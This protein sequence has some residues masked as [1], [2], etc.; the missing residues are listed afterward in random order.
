MDGFV[1]LPPGGPPP[2]KLWRTLDGG[3]SWKQITLP[4]GNLAY[5]APTS[6]SFKN[7]M[8]GWFGSPDGNDLFKTNDGG[9]TWVQIPNITNVWTVFY[10]PLTDQLIITGGS[11]S[12][13][14]ATAGIAFSDSV[15]G[16][17]S[18]AISFPI[19]DTMIYTTDAG[20]SWHH[21]TELAEQYGPIGVKGTT[22]FYAMR[23][24]SGWTNTGET[25]TLVRSDDGGK[26]WRKIYQYHDNSDLAV[27][28]TLQYNSKGIFFQTVFNNSE[29]IMMSEDSGVSF[30]S[31]CGPINNVDTRFY[32]RDS[33]LYAGDKNGGLC[34]NTTGIGSN[35]TPELSINKFSVPAILGCQ[36]VDT[37]ATFTFFDSCNG[38]QAKLV[39]ASLQ[40]SN[41]F[42][43]SSPL[44]IP[45]TIHPD[46][47]LIISYNPQTSK[48]DT[49]QLHLRFHLGWKDFDTVISLT[50]AGRIPKESVQFIPSLSANVSSAGRIVDLLVKPDKLISGRGLN[51]I[52]F[53]LSYY[54]DLLDRINVSSSNANVS[55]ANGTPVRNGKI[56]TLPISITGNDIALDPSIPIA[57]VKFMA[58]LTDTN[59]TAITMS[60]L[61]LNGGN[62]DYHDC[63]LAA[64]SSNTNFSLLF[65]CGD[66]TLYHFM[67]TKKIL[68]IISIRPNPAQD[69]LM[70]D[71]QSA[72]KQDANIEIRNAL[73][74]KVYSGIKY[75][76]SGSNSI[77]VDTKV[78][79]AGM[80]LVRV[81]SASQSL[82]I[83]R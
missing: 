42:S 2:Q 74:A 48:P 52:S 4:L 37:F 36:K 77:H 67:R 16:I 61:K 82:V 21:S 3:K 15:H 39:S 51:S 41:N 29:G 64:D 83:S 47:S 22:I 68:E 75:L 70:I 50:G 35:S 58:M 23:E 60:N 7:S 1:S 12:G 55:I 62:P 34:V 14:P 17:I 19:Q 56:E 43:F 73:G 79:A 49:A 59:S 71:L 9:D 80:Y 6:F 18:G 65:M 13:M 40:G 78:L 25:G 31:I 54:G 66:S 69:E 38:I 20:I 72:I 28:G 45:R 27:T 53:N 57:D 30:H 44:A 8:E 81:G 32:V 63:I 10:V 33:F 11:I 26:K 76:T 24:Q 5:P 46:D